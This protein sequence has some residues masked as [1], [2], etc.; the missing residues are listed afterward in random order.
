LYLAAIRSKYSHILTSIKTELSLTDKSESELKSF[1]E[2]FMPSC[3]LKL[4]A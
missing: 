3:G 4:K 1:L 2:E